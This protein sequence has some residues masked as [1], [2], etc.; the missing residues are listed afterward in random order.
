MKLGLDLFKR[1]IAWKENIEQTLADLTK[2]LDESR[3]DQLQART[4][5]LQLRTELSQARIKIEELEQSVAGKVQA[6]TFHKEAIL[7]LANRVKQSALLE[8]LYE[9]LLSRRRSELLVLLIATDCPTR[10]PLGGANVSDV[11]AAVWDR[12]LDKAFLI[13]DGQGE[14]AVSHRVD[15]LLDAILQMPAE[16]Y[17]W[18]KT[19][20]PQPTDAVESKSEDYFVQVER[21]RSDPERLD[22]YA[23]GGRTNGPPPNP[24][25]EESDF[26]PSFIPAEAKRRS[27]IFLHNSYYHFNC[28]SAGL[29]TR[30][31]DAVT[32]SCEAAD[33]PQRQFHHGEDI[34]LHDAD[35]A[36]MRRKIAGFFKTVPERFS[37]LHFCGQGFASFFSE[38]IEND[39]DPRLIPWDFL[40][41]RR[42]RMAIG[43]T[44]SGCLDGAM[45]SSIRDLTGG[46]CSR[47]VWE[48]RPDVCSD[49]RNL[50]WNRKLAV[51]C[52]W[53]GLE[54]DHATPERVGAKTV[55]GPVVT[56]LDPDR[57]HPDIEVPPEMDTGRSPDEVIVYHAVGNYD[58]RRAGDRDIKG[59]GSLMNAI[60]TLK[61]EGL[62]VRLIFAHDIPSTKVRFLQVQADI[63]VDQL[64]Y[65]RYGA[66]AREALM[67]GKPTICRLSALQSRPQ[68]PLRPIQ[69][70]PMIDAS[71]ETIVDVLRTLV[72]NPERRV[73]LA[74]RAR[75]FALAWHGQDACAE[76]YERVIDRIHSNL[77]PESPDLYPSEEASGAWLT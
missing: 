55:Y 18:A 27:A 77:P 4:E 10:P 23:Q 48:L 5:L 31:W 28:L 63:V 71:E 45:Q 44:P 59:T 49:A 32:V 74:R 76:R 46:L 67:L 25:F 51:L 3:E 72:L 9:V 22:F 66:N 33:S 34:N 19:R 56:T 21:I 50:A 38:N 58:A 24:P 54:C 47:C 1:G 53:V 60:E 30:G 65:G 26:L 52:D 11:L 15:E 35:P 13:V 20:K 70:V 69:E 40:E 17:A 62:P 16:A 42:H 43:Y 6:N 29:R 12:T 37:A 14:N 57:W 8:G 2:Q 7:P 39:P 68:L 61:A 75:A 41:L 73:N 36:V 64:N